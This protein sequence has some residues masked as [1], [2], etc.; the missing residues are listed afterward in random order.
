MNEIEEKSSGLSFGSPICW[1]KLRESQQLNANLLKDCESWRL[2]SQGISRSNKNGWHSENALFRRP[3]ASFKVL[4]EAIHQCVLAVTRKSAP[5]LEFNYIDIQYSGWI[6]M[7]PTNA[8]NSPHRHAG[9]IW[10]GTYYVRIPESANKYSG[11]IEFFDPR[12]LGASNRIKESEVFAER[13]KFNPQSGELV[14][15]PSY[16]LHWVT[17]NVESD[18]RVSI[19]FNARIRTKESN[20]NAP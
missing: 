12:N 3:E 1:F 13:L 17:P 9:Y 11:A 10:S 19:A 14:V 4:C 15:F 7:S 8:F 16:L 6:N 2:V 5:S 20:G 18:E